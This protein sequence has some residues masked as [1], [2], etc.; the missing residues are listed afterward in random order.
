MEI[1]FSYPFFQQILCQFG[2]LLLLHFPNHRL[3]VQS[4]KTHSD[5]TLQLIH[6]NFSYYPNPNLDFSLPCRH[7][8]F[9]ETCKHDSVL[10][11]YKGHERRI[12]EVHFTH[13]NVRCLR[14]PWEL[15]HELIIQLHV[16]RK[17][18]HNL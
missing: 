3:T 2:Y 13:Q 11:P 8:D 16:E 6:N 5:H 7:R 15:L 1:Y 9:S 4:D 14:I 12:Q 18:G 17:M 10:E